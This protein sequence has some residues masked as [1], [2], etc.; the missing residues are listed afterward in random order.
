MAADSGISHTAGMYQ[1]WHCHYH[2]VHCIHRDLQKLRAVFST[3]LNSINTNYMQNSHHAQ[4][5]NIS[6]IFLYSG[7][8]F[9]RLDTHCAWAFVDKIWENR[10]LVTLGWNGSEWT[11]CGKLRNYACSSYFKHTITITHLMLLGQRTWFW[12]VF[13]QL[14]LIYWLIFC[15]KC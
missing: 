3:T 15:G 8:I 12:L 1:I 13:E 7:S 6:G 2:C 9:I 14:Y 4:C 10:H 11:S 5:Y